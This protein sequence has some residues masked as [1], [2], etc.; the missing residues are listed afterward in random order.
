MVKRAK[1][2]RGS[3]RFDDSKPNHFFFIV[4]LYLHLYFNLCLYSVSYLGEPGSIGLP[5]IR[6]PPGPHGDHGQPGIKHESS[7]NINTK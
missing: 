5:G 3:F 7:F 4:Y 1:E 2:V 6:G